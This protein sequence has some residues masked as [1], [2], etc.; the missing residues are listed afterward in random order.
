MRGARII[1]IFAFCLFAA[2]ASADKKAK[3]VKFVPYSKLYGREL[4]KNPDF[5][6]VE[7]AKNIRW[8]KFWPDKAER[9]LIMKLNRLNV[10]LKGQMIVA[11]PKELAG[12][13][14]IDFS[15]HPKKVESKGEKFV[16]F[17]PALLAWAAYDKD[18]NLVRWGPAL[19]GQDYCEDIRRAC[20]TVIGTFRV[21]LKGNANSRSSVY[22]LGCGSKKKPCAAMPWIMYFYKHLYG[23]H[24]STQMIGYNASHG[25][26]RTFADDAEWL[27]KHFTEIGTMVVVRPYSY[28]LK[29]WR[30]K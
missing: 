11:V 25:C 26:V 27:N 5:R 30:K 16:V 21:E 29:K 18:G 15:P 12:K 13:T 3:R 17:D 4:C 14:L 8:E 2:P 6:C 22:P 20:R 28:P 10:L 9:E 1:L 7:I 24:G 23:I 19:G